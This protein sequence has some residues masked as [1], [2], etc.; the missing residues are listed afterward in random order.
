MVLSWRLAPSALIATSVIVL[1]LATIVALLTQGLSRPNTYPAAIALWSVLTGCIILA[2]LFMTSTFFG[3]PERGA[4]IIAR[5]LKQNDLAV[6]QGSNPAIDLGPGNVSLP[7]PYKTE[8]N[9][10]GE[11]PSFRNEDP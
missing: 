3:F 4:T 6:L 10:N 8:P 1:A 11:Y 5:L 2:I 9:A 7:A